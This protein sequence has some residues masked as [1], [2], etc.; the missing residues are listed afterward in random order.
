MVSGPRKVGSQSV[1]IRE[2]I[3]T[4]LKHLRDHLELTYQEMAQRLS[5]KTPTYKNWEIGQNT[6][7]HE[8]MHLI[9]REFGVSP[10]YFFSEV[11]LT[12]EEAR[13]LSRLLQ[14]LKIAE[15]EAEL[16]KGEYLRLA[17]QAE[18]NISSVL[19]KLAPSSA[20]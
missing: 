1:D 9:E 3:A 17:D 18:E 16:W 6:L 11:A 8:A 14:R 13:E 2:V 7:P 12:V 19:Q 5:A 20:N 15:K 10:V 4:R